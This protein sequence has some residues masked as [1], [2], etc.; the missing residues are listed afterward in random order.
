[1]NFFQG[2]A[3]NFLLSS[4]CFKIVSG[5]KTRELIKDNS[6][7][8]ILFFEGKS[9]FFVKFFFRSE[10]SSEKGKQS[11][12]LQ[13]YDLGSKMSLKREKVGV[14]VCGK[15]CQGSSLYTCCLFDCVRVCVCNVPSN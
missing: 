14:R 12:S 11:F 1:M 7:L 9:S 6:S 8:C 5:G 4:H 2:E 13:K 10:V 3:T 15:F